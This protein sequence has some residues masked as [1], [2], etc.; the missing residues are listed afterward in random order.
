MLVNAGLEELIK[1]VKPAP[2]EETVSKK[3]GKTGTG[4]GAK[5]WT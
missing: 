1:F 3:K 2:I 5:K 4:G